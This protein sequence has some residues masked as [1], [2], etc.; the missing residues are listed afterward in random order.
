M[1]A[2]SAATDGGKEKMAWYAIAKWLVTAIAILT[3]VFYLNGVAFHEG[4]LGYFHLSSSMFPSDVPDTLTF[5]ALAWMGGATRVFTAISDTFKMHWAATTL[6]PAISIVV[7][8]VGAY[9]LRQLAER[10]RSS[11]SHQGT[12]SL[13]LHPAVKLAAL[14]VFSA[15]FGA[16]MLYTLCLVIGATLL[17]LVAPFLH[18]GAA[19][20]AEDFARG[21][22]N[23]PAIVV[24]SPDGVL[25]S[26]RIMQCSDR[27]CA[28][29]SHEEVVTVPI[30]SVVWATS[31]VQH[32]DGATSTPTNSSR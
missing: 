5:A 21:F 12:R 4:Y 3:P 15:F 31:R 1:D 7:L 29:F 27:F 28:L 10:W 24:T 19:T 22:P 11:R 30:G 9:Y 20:A 32:S 17:L 16:Y 14:W 25:H 6:V 26:Y 18:V 23:A 13:S 2:E 8:A